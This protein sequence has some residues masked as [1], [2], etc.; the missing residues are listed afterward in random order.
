MFEFFELLHLFTDFL[1]TQIHFTYMESCGNDT[2]RNPNHLYWLSLQLHLLLNICDAPSEPLAMSSKVQFLL[3]IFLLLINIAADWNSFLS[4]HW[5]PL[6][7]VLLVKSFPPFQTL[8]SCLFLMR[9]S[10]TLAYFSW[11]G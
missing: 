4:F 10:V 11:L 3:C 7:P 9:P 2:N 5:P 6:Y 1:A 8:Q